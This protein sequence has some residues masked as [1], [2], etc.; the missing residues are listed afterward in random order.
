MTRLRINSSRKETGFVVVKSFV[1]GRGSLQSDRVSC[2]LF[3]SQRNPA[4]RRQFTRHWTR[5]L[6]LLGPDVEWHLQLSTDKRAVATALAAHYSSRKETRFVVV[7]SLVTGPGR[8]R[9]SVLT[10]S[11][12][13]KG[14][15]LTLSHKTLP[16][17]PRRAFL[18]R[19]F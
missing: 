6:P 18:S 10:L 3:K 14:Q 1:T 7:N 11:G 12:T 19:H 13:D 16:Q 4:C 8:Y 5:S 2:A 15:S 17:A 9:S